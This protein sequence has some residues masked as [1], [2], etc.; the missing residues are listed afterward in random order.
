MS[1]ARFL[2]MGKFECVKSGYYTFI[3]QDQ[4]TL[5]KFESEVKDED[6]LEVVEVSSLR[7]ISQEGLPRPAIPL[8]G[9]EGFDASDVWGRIRHAAPDIASKFGSKD[10]DSSKA[11]FKLITRYQPTRPQTFIALSYC[12]HNPTW[13]L[14]KHIKGTST[15]A[16]NFSWPIS[17]YMTKA[18]L[19]ERM[20]ADEGIWVDQCCIDQTNQ[21]EKSLTI[22]FMDAIYRQA[23]LIVVALED[24]AVSEDEEDFFEDL[25][26]KSNQEAYKD[27]FVDAGSAWCAASLCL[28]IFSARWFSRAWC[29]H[30]FL[31]GRSHVFLITVEPRASVAARVLRLTAAFLRS[32]INVTTDYIEW[33]EVKDESHDLIKSGYAELRENRLTFNLSEHLDANLRLHH[34]E[35]DY[36]PIDPTDLKSFL[37]VF[38]H[39]SSLKASLEVD[40]LVITLNVLGCE[41]YLREANMNRSECG[42][43]ISVLALAAGDPTVLCSSGINFKLSGQ[44]SPQSWFQWPEL[45][46]FEGTS[47]RWS[48]YRRLD[49]VPEFSREHVILD[50]F[51]SDDTT[52]H[53]ASEP[54]IAQAT[55]FI[56]GRTEVFQEENSD[57]DEDERRTEWMRPRSIHIK[58]WACALECG[59]ECIERR[60][61]L[62]SLPPPVL[63]QALRTC[64]SND[65]MNNSF[66]KLYNQYQ[67]QYNL[68][69][70]I[71]EATTQLYFHLSEPTYSPAWISVGPGDA[72]KILIMCPSP[73]SYEI[74]IPKLLLNNDYVNCNRIFFLT[75]VPDT[76]ESWKV[77]GKTVGF[78]ADAM[79]LTDHGRLKENQRI[80]G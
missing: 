16:T 46:D 17:E 13:Q 64:F 65:F 35:G 79:T 52:L 44:E 58:I 27:L 80:V 73:V 2:S 8:S 53:Q 24:I 71:I 72:D 1:Q 12:C 56:D 60:A 37:G 4:C 41:L 48:F 50:M 33:T 62:R 23:R 7:D 54:F 10:N 29:S 43:C 49:K 19:L 69:T 6:G 47:R 67:D 45:G 30:E 78:G 14:S 5:R 75:A 40:K 18:L 3:G 26:D 38:L 76:T 28:K 15:K 39:Y 34:N 70:H 20:S 57:I 74:A 61:K 68:V 77:I 11:P 21:E 31:V 55:W 36:Q 51:F 32:L 25:M 9:I 63:L 22:G 59:V 66:T 42:L